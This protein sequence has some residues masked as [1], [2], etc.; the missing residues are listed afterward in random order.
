M[1][2]FFT[3]VAR[4]RAQLLDMAGLGLLCG[5]GFTLSVTLGLVAGGLACMTAAWHLGR[6]D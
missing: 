5:A 4:N 6:D 3:A 1:T 2:K